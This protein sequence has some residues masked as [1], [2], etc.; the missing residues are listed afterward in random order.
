MNYKA[1]AQFSKS[2]P[3]T[4]IPIHC[5][6]CPTAISGDPQTIWKYNA[7]YHLASE[8]S[9]GITP[10]SIP[11]QLLVQMFIQ[12]EEEMAL[13]I[14]ETVTNSWR[15]QDNI[16]DSDG[17]QEMEQNVQKRER[18]DTVSTS[19]S[20]SHDPKRHRLGGIPE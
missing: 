13:S 5:P 15:E 17:F 20:D 8:H 6:L 14:Q 11:G 4:N 12:K 7:L 9:T 1:A 2:S 16:P 18:S 10:P 19:H 3:C